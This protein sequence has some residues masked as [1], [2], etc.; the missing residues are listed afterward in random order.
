MLTRVSYVRAIFSVNGLIVAVYIL[1]GVFV[2]TAPPHI[3][4]TSNLGGDF[5][6]SW[7]QYAISVL[8]WPLSLWHP[9]FTVGKWT[10]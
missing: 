1:V 6:H 9:S 7:A 8:F 2:N 4:S 5:L 10:P 3:P